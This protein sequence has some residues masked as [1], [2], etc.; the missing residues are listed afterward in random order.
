M[1]PALGVND[2]YFSRDFPVLAAIA[3]WEAGGRANGH[4]RPETIAEEIGQP[5][6]QVIQSIG[7]LFHSG[8]VDAADVTTF[9][10]EDYM[11]R[12]LTGAGLQESGLWP[13]PT[14][15][16]AAL[17][18]VL[19]R[20]AQVVERTDPERGLKMRRVL[21]EIGELGTSFAAKLAI[22]LLKYVSGGH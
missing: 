10:G 21:D 9:G 12:R 4:L 7:R 2:I 22:E 8:L 5:L 17:R 13:K 15:L 16:A 1:D 18:Q 3:R 6:D 11:V 20:E 19:E 14:D